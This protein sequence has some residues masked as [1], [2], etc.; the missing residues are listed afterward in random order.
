MEAS[1]PTHPHIEPEPPEWQPRALI[2]GAR[3]LAGAEAFFFISFVFAYFYLRSLDENKSWKIGHVSPPI[4]FGIGIVV[5]LAASAV[6]L[7]SASKRPA[8]VLPLSAGALA[9]A[10]AAVAVQC[11]QYTV[12]D[13]GP[14]NGA[15]ASVFFGWT[16]TY[17]LFAMFCVY[18]IETQVASL[19]RMRRE[20]GQR[21]REEG[22]PTHD[23]V[24]A[25]AGVAACS[26]FWAYYAALGFIAFVIL[27]LI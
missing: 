14:G 12:L 15:Y 8:A 19:W 27:Y 24:L 10:L 6:L 11:I 2:I 21:P 25:E 5:A 4:G 20:G 26:F 9:L 22:V 13:F 7:W 18:W 17:T 16:I 1:A 23:A 3:L